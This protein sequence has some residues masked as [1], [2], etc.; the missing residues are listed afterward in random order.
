MGYQIFDIGSPVFGKHIAASSLRNNVLALWPTLGEGKSKF[1][2]RLDM[3]EHGI[4][5][6]DDD[7]HRLLYKFTG[8]TI[9]DLKET[10]RKDGF[11]GVQTSYLYFKPIN[12][13]NYDVKT[14]DLKELII[15]TSNKV[16]SEDDSTKILLDKN[17]TKNAVIY[18]NLNYLELQSNGP[19]G[20]YKVGVSKYASISEHYEAMLTDILAAGHFELLY[21]HTLA[22]PASALALFDTDNDLY[23]VKISYAGLTNNEQPTFSFEYTL[24]VKEAKAGEG[25]YILDGYPSYEYAARVSYAYNY[26]KPKGN[27]YVKLATALALGGGLKSSSTAGSL[28]AELKRVIAQLVVRLHPE[29]M[30]KAF[31]YMD[32]KNRLFD[33]VKDAE[34]IRMGLGNP[35]LLYDKF[36][37]LKVIQAQTLFG[38][39]LDSDYSEIEATTAEKIFAVVAA[40]IQIVATFT[41]QIYLV[42]L[43]TMIQVIV[44]AR[45]ADLGH[46][47]AITFMGSVAKITAVATAVIGIVNVLKAGIS[48]AISQLTDFSGLSGFA[49]TTKILNIVNF[50]AGYVE[51]YVV[52]DARK[53]ANDAKDEYNDLQKQMAMMP[54]PM[55][56]ELVQWD[57]ETYNFL[58]STDRLDNIPYDKT[59]GKV[60]AATHKYYT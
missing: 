22:E 7:A 15:S 6:Y 19:Y 26:S 49:L 20:A 41:G 56:T 11:K 55:H 51:D 16:P 35:V 21:S 57:F 13:N 14:N 23:D 45:L 10:N 36:K 5:V 54:T 44:E 30:D 46:S 18:I 38:L 53:D 43:I 25:V 29:L 42:L 58:E 59:E 8:V 4:G 52:E 2:G 17:Q 33:P 48:S 9:K 3:F 32:S 24:R 37:G 40:I 28:G 31:G 12:N 47:G 27:K 50:V 39:A 60:R 34:F 1:F